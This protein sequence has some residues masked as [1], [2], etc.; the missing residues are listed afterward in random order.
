MERHA[1]GGDIIRT[2]FDKWDKN[3]DGALQVREARDLLRELKGSEVDD[4][5]IREFYRHLD[6]NQDHKI[7]FDEFQNGYE[8][9]V[10]NRGRGS[11]RHGGLAS[12]EAKRQRDE[13]RTV[14]MQQFS[15]RYT[16][17]EQLDEILKAHRE[18]DLDLRMVQLDVPVMSKVDKVAFMRNAMAAFGDW[19]E[20]LAEYMALEY[21]NPNG[22]PLKVLKQV[23]DLLQLPERVFS[24][25]IDRLK[26]TGYIDKVFNVVQTDF[27]LINHILVTLRTQT[28]DIP[29]DNEADQMVLKM[30]LSV[31]C[32]FLH[33]DRL[34]KWN[35]DMEALAKVKRKEHCA[36]QG[37]LYSTLPTLLSRW[38]AQLKQISEEEE[39]LT[40]NSQEFH[41][42][43]ELVKC[44]GAAAEN[45][46]F[47]DAPDAD[48]HCAPN[49]G[50]VTL[51]KSLFG[52]H[53]HILSILSFPNIPFELV[54]A[55]LST[56]A[57]LLG[58]TQNY[59]DVTDIFD[60]NEEMA[61]HYTDR[62]TLTLKVFI[63]A[64]EQPDAAT[65]SPFTPFRD[66]FICIGT[67]IFLILTQIVENVRMSPQGE[68]CDVG[69]ISRVF[70]SAPAGSDLNA[71][72]YAVKI[73]DY[74]WNA[75][76]CEV[77]PVD[78]KRVSSPWAPHHDTAGGRCILL[79]QCLLFMDGLCVPYYSETDGPA[80]TRREVC[81]GLW[82][83]PQLR[84]A[85]H[86]YFNSGRLY[87]SLMSSDDLY[88]SVAGRALQI[89]R[90]F[91]KSDAELAAGVVRE[92][93]SELV[94]MLASPEVRDAAL[95]VLLE[96]A[97]INHVR[98]M[99]AMLAPAVHCN[100]LDQLCMSLLSFK[101]HHELLESVWT[102]TESSPDWA[103]IRNVL[104]LVKRLSETT[105]GS[106]PLLPATAHF[107]Q[108]HID[109][110]RSLVTL[111]VSEIQQRHI[112]EDTYN[113][114][115]LEDTLHG[116][117]GCLMA[118][119][120]M[121]DA[122]CSPLIKKSSLSLSQE[123]QNPIQIAFREVEEEG[124]DARW[125]EDAMTVESASDR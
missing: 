73:I 98:E 48:G 122:A 64:A 82:V 51:L 42:L 119:G 91:C 104:T 120:D 1:L 8:I 110:F 94:R 52:L 118:L 114:M 105:H 14:E 27:P 18:D 99:P 80:M 24:T 65:G 63:D 26:H 55:V 31:L 12:P 72:N 53:S 17:K 112:K 39:L 10:N 113:S 89:L 28:G 9:F 30:S 50:A 2:L 43:A 49:A 101:R 15:V 86:G 6:K 60:M 123:L 56:L 11:K 121:S 25:E 69:F 111:F 106:V 66:E 36:T 71:L 58:Y 33:E 47:C 54:K 40:P 83:L 81:Q 96:C 4:E 76:G 37:A 85:F 57:I 107:H 38:M 46:S 102:G 62:L 16:P 125:G 32:R 7:S 84:H 92:Y 35:S 23:D 29:R 44:I 79:R 116:I 3:S 90:A 19:F 20:R 68:M 124:D 93:G 87:V 117:R 97:S 108:Y 77:N 74:G 34:P 61:K 95:A 67:N 70:A 100:L 59:T 5:C 45:M 13:V 22:G 21:R 75:D 115:C 78:G 41:V 109:S 103:Y 88:G